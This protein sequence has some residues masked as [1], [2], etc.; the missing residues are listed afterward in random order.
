MRLFAEA[1]FRRADAPFLQPAGVFLDLS[2]EDI[3]RRLFL[4]A[5]AEGRELCL[6]PEFTI[7][8][9]RDYIAGPDLGLEARLAYEGPVFR[10]RGGEPGEFRQAGVESLAREDRAAAD[11]EIACLAMAAADRMGRGELALRLG[12]IAILE[13]GIAGIGLP[14]AVARRL[15][16]GLATGRS[17]PVSAGGEP[18][19]LNDFDGVL[20]TLAGV[21]PKA[22]RAFVTDLLRIAGVE[23]GGGRTTAEIA[24][25]FL[26]RAA[27]RS[28]GI[29][30]EQSAMAD[31]LTAIA[32]D[33]D[34][35]AAALRAFATDTGIDFGDTLDRYEERTGFMAAGG[36]DISRVRA[37]AGF[38]RSIDYYTG[39][40]FELVDDARPDLRPL[41]GGGRYDRLLK[42]LGAPDDIPAVGFSV[43]I[44]RLWPER[45]VA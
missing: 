2:G 25:R 24:D 13:K 35:V 11:A 44:E 31:R 36:L 4:T 5:D 30:A 32:G 10:H 14:A 27:E 39:M 21:E 17:M 15:K 9:C 45:A 26:S 3:R 29:S 38:A 40:V 33:P 20:K 1:G 16:R 8:L 22:A 34:E 12:D 37:S 23:P 6:R 43:W 19:G 18:A 28:G 42:R 41:I 7:P